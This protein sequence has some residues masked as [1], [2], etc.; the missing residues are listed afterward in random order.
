M[1]QKP[2]YPNLQFS[3]NKTACHR[4]IKVREKVRQVLP[5]LLYTNKIFNYLLQLQ[6]HSCKNTHTH[7]NSLRSQRL[8]QITTNQ[9]SMLNMR[10][11]NILEKKNKTNQVT[12]YQYALQKEV[13]TQ[14][15][16]ADPAGVR[17]HSFFRGR[18]ARINTG[19]FSQQDMLQQS[20]QIQRI[21]ASSDLKETQVKMHFDVKTRVVKIGH[22]P[23]IFSG[24]A[25]NIQLQN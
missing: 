16:V 2:T 19:E 10:V 14:L 13:D 11:V 18:Y 20:F 21:L 17:I 22:L 15:S 23:Q 5:N 6:K 1:L 8:S 3:L 7:E 25:S 4:I 12:M 24:S 9:K